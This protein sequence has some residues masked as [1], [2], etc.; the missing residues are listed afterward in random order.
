MRRSP[1]IL[2]LTGSIAMGKSEAAKVFGRLGV[3][4]F[5]ADAAVHSM[6]ARGGEAVEVVA[7]SFPGVINDGAI[8]RQRLGARVFG[9]GNELQKL[10]LLLHPL[11]GAARN[12]FLRRAGGSRA[13]VVVMDVPL[14]FE[15][16]GMAGYHAVVVVTAPHF[17][18]R[19]RVLRRPGMTADRLASILQR[20]VPDRLKR[21]QA[22]FIVC[23]GL[24]KRSALISIRR[25]LCAVRAGLV[26]RDNLGIKGRR[27]A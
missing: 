5:D 8:D 1:I 18:Q 11:V 20:Q 13:G 25:I 21:R 23:S 9:K 19:S 6:L 7:K 14:L 22:D 3:P 17:V 26:C 12:K 2:G 4:V 15:T 16:G 10:E 24:G 27:S